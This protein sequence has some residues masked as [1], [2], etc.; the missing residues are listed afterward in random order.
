MARDAEV[1][2]TQKFSFSGAGAEWRVAIGMSFYRYTL[3]HR[4]A[5]KIPEDKVRAQARQMRV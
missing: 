5:S 1:D 2:P 3:S 4:E